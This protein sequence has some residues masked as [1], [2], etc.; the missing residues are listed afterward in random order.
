MASLQEFFEHPSL[1]FLKELALPLAASYPN[2]KEWNNWAEASQSF[3]THNPGLRFVEEIRPG[4]RKRRRE[5]KLTPPG[6]RSYEARVIERGEIATRPDHPHDFFNGMIWL[7]YPLSKKTLHQIAYELQQSNTGT[8][9]LRPADGLTCF[10]EGGVIYR[11]REGEDP[12]EILAFLYSR[13]DARKAR[14]C[15][16]NRQQFQV[17]GHGILE[18]LWVHGKSDLQVATAVLP[19]RPGAVAWDAELAVYLAE[20]A[21]AGS[22][23]GTSPFD[24]LWKL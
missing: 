24:S 13:E 1:L 21:R 12:G 3:Q 5:K 20:K 15:Q 7:R 18:A 19:Y 6:Q 11:C 9:R 22:C 2:C 17:F 10:D 16:D 23:W 14:F 4:A 8:L